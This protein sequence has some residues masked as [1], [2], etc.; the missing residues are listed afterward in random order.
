MRRYLLASACLLLGA[1]AAT[2]QVPT[3][4]SSAA[5]WFGSLKSQSMANFDT[6]N[7][8]PNADAIT[9]GIPT[10]LLPAASLPCHQ[11]GQVFV[12]SQDC[13]AVQFTKQA[14]SYAFS[15]NAANNDDGT[16]KPTGTAP[17]ASG[18]D[19]V[20]V[21]IGADQNSFNS[22]MWGV[23]EVIQARAGGRGVAGAEWDLNRMLTCTSAADEAWA[24]HTN[25]TINDPAYCPQF[26][27]QWITGLNVA[28]TTGGPAVF[29]TSVNG[30]LWNDG[31]QLFGNSVR[32]TGFMDASNS[33]TVLKAHGTHSYGED[34]QNA[35]LTK[36]AVAFMSGNFWG[37][38][39]TDATN[40]NGQGIFWFPGPASNGSAGGTDSIVD[41]G[42]G[43]TLTSSLVSAVRGPS[44][45]L[46]AGTIF[47][48]PAPGTAGNAQT[49]Y[50][51]QTPSNGHLH[52]GQVGTTG[53]SV[54][55]DGTL[56]AS[57]V[58]AKLAI[59][60]PPIIV[61]STT[62]QPTLS[63]DGP[64]G[65][66]RISNTPAVMV[67]S[68]LATSGVV[69]GS[70]PT[71]RPAQLALGAYGSGNI[72]LTPAPGIAESGTNDLGTFL[73]GGVKLTGEIMCQNGTDTASWH[74]AATYLVKSSV[75]T[76]TG[77][78]TTVD[79]PP[80]SG[81]TSWL[82]ATTADTANSSPEIV[83][84]VGSA[85][86]SCSASVSLLTVN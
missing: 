37:P 2:A 64:T 50:F 86:A 7:I 13:R 6:V 44:V 79:V 21:Y 17:G 54:D 66:L 85:T 42:S 56:T 33:V 41:N 59:Y 73:S 27:G 48:N 65:N 68:L 9:D 5:P 1:P 77:L 55:V 83:A 15:L 35:H 84:G 80:T 62:Y 12:L 70:S 10:K 58:T 61:G 29:V 3:G 76:L 53:G 36:A 45:E 39:E 69:Y 82:L 52:I 19:K 63:T 11:V 51:Q 60:L 18:T 49:P 8:D 75:L 23:N 4:P 46:D 43:L 25:S 67:P 34:W 20:V 74:I 22:D 30:P 26:L 32:D 28:G 31:V 14:Q 78:T 38:S 47:V 40:P 81:A 57:N 24:S 16:G 71:H 72:A